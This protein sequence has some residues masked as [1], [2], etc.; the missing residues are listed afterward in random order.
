[1][2]PPAHG[3]VGASK[4]GGKEMGATRNMLYDESDINREARAR[5]EMLSVRPAPPDRSPLTKNDRAARNGA[6]FCLGMVML[7]VSTYG[8]FF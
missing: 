2:S 6:I 5:A 7:L 1:M 4:K 3:Q 8:L